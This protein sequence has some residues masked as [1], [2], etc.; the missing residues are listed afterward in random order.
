MWASSTTT[1]YYL[2]WSKNFAHFGESGN[3]LQSCMVEKICEVCTKKV[4]KF[5]LLLIIII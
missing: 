4:Y 5:L 3:F 1:I 2:L